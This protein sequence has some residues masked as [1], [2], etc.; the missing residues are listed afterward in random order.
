M[1][2]VTWKAC[3][4][5]L[6]RHGYLILDLS[7]FKIKA[8]QQNQHDVVSFCESLSQ[9]NL[10]DIVCE[11]M[12]DNTLTAKSLQGI[13]CQALEKLRYHWYEEGTP[14]TREGLYQTSIEVR[15]TPSPTA[16]P[17]FTV[18]DKALS[19]RCEAKETWGTR[20]AMLT[21][22]SASCLRIIFVR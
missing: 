5:E 1:K 21:M 6:E 16:E 14:C 10:Y 8:L 3:L 4:L 15:S 20:L 18:Y 11:Y 2:E 22:F 19:R 13:L 12:F 17:M 7:W 9:E